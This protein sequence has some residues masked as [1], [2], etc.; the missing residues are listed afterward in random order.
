MG[1]QEK[2]EPLRIKYKHYSV[3]EKEHYYNAWRISGLSQNKF[4]QKNNLVLTTFSNWV[5]KI[6][7]S[8]SSKISFIPLEVSSETEENESIEIQFP[9]GVK[10][11]IKKIQDIKKISHLMK[12]L[13]NAFAAY[14]S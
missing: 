5:K 1:A 3:E 13:H 14:S 7:K 6:K 2:L 8:P 12:E 11:Q 10:C 9:N 4:C